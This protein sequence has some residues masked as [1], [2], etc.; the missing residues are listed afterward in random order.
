MQQRVSHKKA[1]KDVDMAQ[2]PASQDT[3][4]KWNHRKIQNIS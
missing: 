4:I 1:D 3:V 2:C